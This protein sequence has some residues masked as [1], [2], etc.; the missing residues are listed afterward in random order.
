MLF[1]PSQFLNREAWLDVTWSHPHALKNGHCCFSRDIC[2]DAMPWECPRTRLRSKQMQ[3]VW[4]LRPGNGEWLPWHFRFPFMDASEPSHFPPQE[5]CLP[6]CI[7]KH[8]I[9]LINTALGCIDKTRRRESLMCTPSAHPWYPRIPW[10]SN[11]ISSH[12]QKVPQQEIWSNW[13]HSAQR[14]F[15]GRIIASP[16]KQ[17]TSYESFSD[18]GEI[19]VY[20]A[21]KILTPCRMHWNAFLIA[22]IIAKYHSFPNMYGML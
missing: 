17:K 14:T 9:A 8:C 1:W 19:R 10:S 4:S 2:V 11:T 6:A 3:A 7:D 13:H 22:Q 18:G 15:I 12:R 20:F 16:L 21:S 5:P